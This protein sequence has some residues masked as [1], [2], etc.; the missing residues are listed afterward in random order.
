MNKFSKSTKIIV[1]LVLGL[2]V[3][4]VIAVSLGGGS[5]KTAVVTPT[6]APLPTYSAPVAPAPP[7]PT[8]QAPAPAQAPAA[9]AMTGAQSQAVQSAQGYLSDGQGFSQEGRLQQLTSSYGEGFAKADAQFAINYLHPNW[10]AQA[11]E[12]AQG[13]MNDGQGFSRS[14]LTQ[15]LTSSYG[16]GFTQAQANYA[17]N[18][19]MG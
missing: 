5:H 10:D 17:V 3:I 13:Y 14:A 15:Q 4:I 6:N 11:V 16:E 18:K 9:P 7:A 1:G 12:S 19:V 8:T 2:L